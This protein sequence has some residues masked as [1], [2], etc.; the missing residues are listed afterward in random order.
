[1]AEVLASPNAPRLEILDSTTRDFVSPS[2]RIHGGAD[3][4]FF[5]TSKA[6]RDVITFILQLNRAL[7]P[8]K[9]ASEVKTWTLEQHENGTKATNKLRAMLATMT[10]YLE[11]APPDEGPRRFGNASFRKWYQL[12]E[13]NADSL[14]TEHLE[15]PGSQSLSDYTGPLQELKAYLLGA[16]GSAQRLDYGTGHELSFIAFLGAVWK[17]GGFGGTNEDGA[18]ERAIVLDVFEP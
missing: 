18:L 10:K 5:L 14:L 8:R 12:V 1:M 9:S 11:S 13:E 15:V 17:V 6:Y 16:F 4:S 2:K 3:V 7:F